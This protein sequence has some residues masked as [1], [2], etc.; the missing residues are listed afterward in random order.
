MKLSDG[1]TT[2]DAKK[3]KNEVIQYYQSLFT[4]RVDHAP[5]PSEIKSFIR[6]Y[7]TEKQRAQLSQEVMAAEVKT[8]LFSLGYNK[9]P[10]PN[11][12]PIEFFIE[13]WQVVGQFFT[14]IV[15]NFFSHGKLLKEVSNTIITLVPKVVNTSSL[16]DYWPFSCC[17]VI[18]KCISKIMA[19]CIASILP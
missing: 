1:S 5:N 15:L 10:G 19:T 3:I 6:I 7:L 4:S 2:T 13:S 16:M 14:D 8:T 9:V 17:N 12:Y 11:G 18:Y